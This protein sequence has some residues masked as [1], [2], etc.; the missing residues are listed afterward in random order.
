MHY[1]TVC[2]TYSKQDHNLDLVGRNLLSDLLQDA[3]ADAGHVQEIFDLGKGSIR[4]AIVEDTL[5]QFRPDAGKRLERG[6][7]RRVDIDLGLRQRLHRWQPNRAL[8]RA[9]DM[10]LLAIG[11][12]MGQVNADQVGFGDGAAGGQKRILDN[13]AWRKQ[14]DV[15]MLHCPADVHAQHSGSGRG[16]GP[17]GRRKDRRGQDQG[18]SITLAALEQRKAEC[19]CHNAHKKRSAR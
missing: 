7:V 16:F 14:I 17:C 1:T 15:R 10:N 19:C 9:G 3:R 11:N 5:R 12:R 18:H 6:P 4:L 2:V 13:A 8:A